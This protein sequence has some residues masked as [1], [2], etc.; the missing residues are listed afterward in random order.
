M[1]LPDPADHI[2]K[3]ILETST[4]YERELLE[5][6]RGRLLSPGIVIDVGANIGNHSLYFAQVLGRKVMAFEPN[7]QAFSILKENI[8]VNDLE[9]LVQ[10]FKMALGNE[11]GEGRSVLPENGNLGMARFEMGQG[12]DIPCDRLDDL[13]QDGTDVA[14]LKIDVEGAEVEVLAGAERLLTEQAP[15]LCVECATRQMRLAVSRFLGKLGYFLVGTFNATPTHIFVSEKHGGLSSMLFD[16][17]ESDA[18][19]RRKEHLR[20]MREVRRRGAS[21]EVLNQLALRARNLEKKLEEQTGRLCELEQAN[22]KLA[23]ETKMYRAKLDL[24]EKERKELNWRVIASQRDLQ[25][26]RASVSYALGHTFVMATKRPWPNLPKLPISLTMLFWERWRDRTGRG[27]ATQKSGWVQNIKDTLARVVR[28]PVKVEGMPLVSVIMPAFNNEATIEKA[29][30]SLL[31]QSYSNLEVIVV[32]DSSSDRTAEVVD[33]VSARDSRVHLVRQR[34][35]MGPY[36]AKNLGMSYAS[37]EFIT[38]HDADDWSDPSRVEKQVALLSKDP[39][40][41]LVTVNFKRID[42]QGNVILNRGL[43]QRLCLATM[44]F[45]RDE[46]ISELGA[47]DLV[48]YG[49]DYEMFCRAKR[50]FGEKAVRN[51]PVALYFALVSDGSLSASTVRL[52]VKAAADEQEFLSES[53]RNYV[54]AFSGFHEEADSLR[55]EFPSM[56]RKFPVPKEMDCLASPNF[57]RKLVATLASIPSRRESLKQVI[58]SI[59]P[60]VDRIGVYL[61]NYEDVPEFLKRD[62]I[63]VARSQD[64]GDLRDN[65]KFFFSE[66]VEDAVH[67]TLDD[68]IH[69]PADYVRY[70]FAKIV[71]YDFKVAVGVHGVVFDPNFRKFL[72]GRYVYHFQESM[73]SDRLV[74]LLGTGT[75]AYDTR[76]VSL[77]HEEIATKGMVDIWFARKAKEAGVP[78]I[79][80]QRDQCF[81]AP[82]EQKSDENLMNLARQDDTEHTR[83]V[84]EAGSWHPG[85]YLGSELLAWLGSGVYNDSLYR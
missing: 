1:F 4:F 53:R 76:T 60:Q 32:D 70:L 47:F 65:G 62:K 12:G 21:D 64:H 13:L 75:L 14:L 10:P 24:L 5:E 23:A 11:R 82:I 22:E 8:A 59:Y 16:R 9:R 36:W 84:R 35:N 28:R 7:D 3:T 6:L 74:N 29:L 72:R 63:V 66:L 80:V 44:M 81:L 77:R 51:L 42:A 33:G 55:Y 15:V 20:I 83:L 30:R 71:Q 38:F 46:F 39:A 43:D 27:G 49:A 45:R 17:L 78:L 31:E 41:K 73:Q 54:A 68:D 69:Y 67:F 85:D 61:N 56:R 25:R 34:R 79:C 48:R 58:D 37:G 40:A 19:E 50:V 2:Q 26:V 57:D 52:D 18:D